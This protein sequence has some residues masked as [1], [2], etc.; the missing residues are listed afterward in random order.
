MSEQQSLRI[1]HVGD[2]YVLLTPQGQ[3]VRI[4]AVGDAIEVQRGAVWCRVRV[5]SGGYKGWY[6][7]AADGHRARFALCMR[8]R[9]VE[10]QQAASSVTNLSPRERL[11]AT[12][13]GKSVQTRVAL[14]GGYVSGVVREITQKG[15]AIFAYVPRANGVPVVASFPVERLDEVLM[16]VLSEKAGV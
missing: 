4:L 9:L 6:Y 11:R 1:G 2:A 7:V 13:V 12:W 14:A 5:E 3:Q 8:V 15:Q 16:L 10:S